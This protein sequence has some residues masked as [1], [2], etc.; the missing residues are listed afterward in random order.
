MRPIW[1][2]DNSI[3]IDTTH[4]KISDKKQNKVKY[5]IEKR[6]SI[7]ITKNE[8][9]LEN[10]YKKKILPYWQK[11]NEISKEE[12]DLESLFE[13]FEEMR[14][15]YMNKMKPIWNRK[16]ELEHNENKISYKDSKKPLDFDSYNS[17]EYTPIEEHGYKTYY[18][19]KVRPIWDEDNE[20]KTMESTMSVKEHEK[21]PF[22]ISNDIKL[23][24]YKEKPMLELSN[25]IKLSYH[26]IEPKK[27]VDL[28]QLNSFDIYHPEDPIAYYKKQMKPIWNNENEL[29]SA[30]PDNRISV[31]DV[32]EEEAFE[33]NNPKKS[34]MRVK[35]KTRLNDTMNKEAVFDKSSLEYP[36]EIETKKYY[37]KKIRPIWNEDN[38]FEHN[39]FNIDATPKKI[40]TDV[41]K[42]KEIEMIH[43]DEPII[44]YRGKM[45][46][47]W[48]ENNEIAVQNENISIKDVAKA[49]IE[50]VEKFNDIALVYPKNAT[51]YYKRKIK[52]IWNKENKLSNS[53]VKIEIKGKAKA[54]PKKVKQTFQEVKGNQ[55]ELLQPKDITYYYQYKIKYLWLKQFKPISS[56]FNYLSKPK[57]KTVTKAVKVNRFDIISCED[58]ITYYKTKMIPIWKE[59]NTKDSVDNQIIKEPKNINYYYQYKLKPIWDKNNQASIISDSISIQVPI[60]QKAVLKANKASALQLLG[61]AKKK[62]ELQCTQDFCYCKC[63]NIYKKTVH[64]P[65]KSTDSDIIFNDE[66]TY[67]IKPQIE[68]QLKRNI[69]LK[70]TK[71]HTEES[72]EEEKDIDIFDNMQRNTR[73]KLDNLF[74][75][76]KTPSVK[77]SSQDIILED[78]NVYKAPVKGANKLKSMPK[79]GKMNKPIE[80]DPRQSYEAHTYLKTEPEDYS[81][82]MSNAQ[83]LLRKSVMNRKNKLLLREDNDDKNAFI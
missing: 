44:Y 7:E 51:V 72:E 64:I 49:K 65:K 16:N 14:I 2:E 22:D 11:R 15:Y 69:I 79:K 8:D 68:D 62:E 70:I 26:E 83:Y 80:T 47:I 38:Q 6:E 4:L 25:D 50:K 1:E 3:S 61:R 43:P 23:S 35:A 21:T 29:I 74:K 13:D 9:E 54:K 46:P 28:E 82:R 34:R 75:N 52:P 59:E 71:L 33:D 31:N 78:E 53:V 12:D 39:S 63:H 19:R 76:L 20:Q 42:G 56:S 41:E 67:A 60:K 18:R 10:Y 81:H 77:R 45:I 36:V 48:E 37:K 40:V 55:F 57:Q 30:K 73:P 27:P 24:Y 17:F 66:E 5:E 32:K 58:P